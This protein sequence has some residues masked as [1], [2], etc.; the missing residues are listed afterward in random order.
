MQ[1]LL[2]LGS[3]ARMNVPGTTSPANWSWRMRAES[4]TTVLA[5]RVAEQVRLSGRACDEVAGEG[6]S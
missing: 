4:L 3:E 1:D 2:G 6:V 5:A